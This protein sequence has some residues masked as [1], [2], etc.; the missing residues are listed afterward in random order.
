MLTFCPFWFGQEG[1]RGRLRSWPGRG[2]GRQGRAG[3][4]DRRRV[5]LLCTLAG[6]KAPAPPILAAWAY[7]VLAHLPAWARL[8]CSF[9]QMLSG[10]S[11]TLAALLA[12]IPPHRVGGD[13]ATVQRMIKRERR[14]PLHSSAPPRPLAGGL[15]C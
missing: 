5:L 8:A 3:Q 10:V 9:P 14:R 7:C 13:D 2:G 4:L 15:P 11:R 12:F 6:A 1:S